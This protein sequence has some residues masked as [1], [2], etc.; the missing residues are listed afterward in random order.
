MYSIVI[1]C[2]HKEN[3]IGVFEDTDNW[4]FQRKF[5]GQPFEELVENLKSTLSDAL[6]DKEKI[7]RFY[8]RIALALH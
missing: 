3:F 7:T 4:V 5:N 1:D 8:T 2:S 6:I